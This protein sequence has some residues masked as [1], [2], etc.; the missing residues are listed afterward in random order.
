MAVQ[1]RVAIVTGGNKGIG[2]AI[3]I[4]QFHLEPLILIITTNTPS[5]S[6]TSPS[7]TQHPLSVRDPSLFISPPAPPRKATKP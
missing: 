4:S 6:V 7:N 2:L 1:S 3:G 5:Q